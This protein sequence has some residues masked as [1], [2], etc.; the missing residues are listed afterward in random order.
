M[1][2]EKSLPRDALTFSH[3]AAYSV[4]HLNNDLG[5]ASLSVYLNWYLNKVVLLDATITGLAFLIGQVADGI[6]TVGVGYF[7]D[8]YGSK[9]FGKRMPWYYIGSL[10]EMAGTIGFF[11]FPK[12]ARLYDLGGKPRNE[13]MVGVYYILMFVLFNVGWAFV[14]IANMSIVNQLTYSNRRRDR[15]TNNRNGFTYG[16][17]IYCLA[18]SMIFF[19]VVD[20]EVDQF[21]YLCLVITVLGICSTIFY[22]VKI[23]EPF[24]SS[25]AKRLEAAY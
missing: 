18:F 20:N 23:Q 5:A 6:A 12:F 13:K 15:L 1:I 11:V 8:N 10:M 17:Y 4:G 25:E 14:Q 2:S 21:R 22:I 7:S 19:S 3:I 9:K 16:S 24:L